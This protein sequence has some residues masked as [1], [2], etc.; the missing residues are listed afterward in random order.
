MSKSIAERK[1]QA[2]VLNP[3][4]VKAGYTTT[5]KGWEGQKFDSTV[6]GEFQLETLTV[7]QVEK[8]IA[9]KSKHF[10]KA[11]NKAEAKK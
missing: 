9:A 5:L 3:E 11:E 8:L 2:A 7:K 6:V 4:V 10:A 1:K